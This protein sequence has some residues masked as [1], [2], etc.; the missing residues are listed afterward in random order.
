MGGL[1]AIKAALRSPADIRRLVLT[2]TSGGLPVDD[3]GGADWRP[4]YRQ[5]FPHAVSWI[6]EH[7]EDLS[8]SLPVITAPTLLLWGDHDTI[9]PLAVGERLAT[10][11]PNAK[12]QCIRGGHHDLAL[13]HPGEVAELITRHLIETSPSTPITEHHG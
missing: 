9:S 10:V 12:L 3:L 5:E 11:L 2:A 1:V 4:Q 13:S 8:S 6:T 7:C